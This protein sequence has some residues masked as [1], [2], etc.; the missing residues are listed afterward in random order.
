MSSTQTVVTAL[1]NAADAKINTAVTDHKLSQ[2]QAQKIE[3]VLPKYLTKAVDRV[4]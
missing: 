1:A 2:A 4:R 3:A